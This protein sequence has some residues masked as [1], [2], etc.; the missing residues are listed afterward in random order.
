MAGYSSTA[1]DKKSSDAADDL[2]IFNAENLQNNLKIIYYRF[3]DA[4]MNFSYLLIR[5]VFLFACVE[6]S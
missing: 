3:F 6:R 4:S 5:I 2:P 1:S